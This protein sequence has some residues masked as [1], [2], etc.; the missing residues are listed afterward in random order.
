MH[1][2][3]LAGT[4]PADHAHARTA[5]SQPPSLARAPP[6]PWIS[7]W[8]LFELAAIKGAFRMDRKAKIL[9]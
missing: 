8:L 9:D 2:L 6:M 3:S 5:P 7:A 1:S 4:R